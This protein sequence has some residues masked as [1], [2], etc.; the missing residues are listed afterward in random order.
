M[1]F[2]KS[3]PPAVAT[4]KESAPR[5]KI[6]IDWGVRKWS[7]L[8][9]APTEKPSRMVT[10][11]IMAVRAV[12]ARRSVTMLSLSRL[13]K[14]SIPISTS[15]PGAIR[16]QIKKPAMG[17]MMRSRRE[18]TRGAFMRMRRSSRVVSSF[19]IGGWMTGTRA[20]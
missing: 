14:K 9:L 18:T 15:E 2:A 13:P 7:A 20:M 3:T 17:K 4:Q 5:P 8:V 16:A 19:M 6:R 10:M 1:N 12:L 11:S